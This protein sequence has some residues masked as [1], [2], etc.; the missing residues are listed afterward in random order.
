MVPMFTVVYAVA[1]L[2]GR[3]SRLPG[4]S[5]SLVWPAAAVA[6]AWLLWASSRGRA[7]LMVS[8]VVLAAVA[9]AINHLTGNLSLPVSLAL[10]VANVIQALVETA[11]LSRLRPDAWRLRRSADLAFW[12]LACLAGAA[13]GS[14][15]G[16]AALATSSHLEFWNLAGAWTL[17]NA[18]NTF[19]FAALALRIAGNGLA[20]LVPPRDRELELVVAT[21]LFTVAYGVVFGLADGLPLSYLVLPLSMWFS[22]RFDTTLVAAHVWLVAAGVLSFTLTGHGPFVATSPAARVLLAQAFV[23]IV[24]LVALV[25]ALHRDERQELITQLRRARATSDEQAQELRVASRHKSDFLATMSH[26]IRTPLNGVLGYT[27]LLAEN[28]GSPQTPEWISGADRA[29]HVLLDIVND[30]LD[31]AKIEAGGID[32]EQVPLDVVAVAR[33]AL[34]PSR[35]RAEQAGIQLTLQTPEG[36]HR[37]RTGDPT[38]LRQILTNLIANAVK[39]TDQG[40]V[41][42]TIEDAGDRVRLVVADTGIGMDT[43][44]MKNLFRPFVQASSDTTRRYGGTGLGL[45]IAQGLTLAM[46][47]H[48]SVSSEPGRGTQMCLL[49]VLPRTTAPVPVAALPRPRR[50]PEATLAGKHVLVAEDNETNQLIAR[51]MLTSRGLVVDMVDDGE[52]AVA[53]VRAGTY[54]AVFMDV[55]MPVLDG[56]EATRR[57]RADELTR[58]LRTPVIA[59]TANAFDDDRQACLEAGMDDFLPKPWKAGQLSEVLEHLATGDFPQRRGKLSAT[60][61]N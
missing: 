24:A 43:E 39:F 4:T 6:F 31:V 46:G 5:L 51:A 38:R 33:E 44:Q 23:A 35:P 40:S 52:A 55:H 2:L 18:T 29:G 30:S 60:P 41:T 37:Y 36:L 11:V 14:L 13:A 17:R 9:T 54:D 15:L 25:L 48:L 27:S 7:P 50:S 26:E 34:L 57:I 16:P 10:G 28:P 53:A 59:M 22:L 19:V 61:E 1:V 32:L 20:G 56:L 47:G 12:V 58:G 8:S 49:V 21:L 42:V 45:S 3:L